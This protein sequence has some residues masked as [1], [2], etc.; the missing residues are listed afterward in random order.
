MKK[1]LSPALFVLLLSASLE[2]TAQTPLKTLL[3]YKSPVSDAAKNYATARKVVLQ[4]GLPIAEGTVEMSVIPWGWSTG[5]HKWH[6]FFS[7]A[8]SS[9]NPER[10]ILLY[11]QTDGQLRLL[12]QE[13]RKNNQVI[14]IQSPVQ[15]ENR[16]EARI[17]FTWKQ[18]KGKC[19]VSLFF[20]G[21][22]LGKQYAKFELATDKLDRN[23]L[24]GDSKRWN[25]SSEFGTA[26]TELVLWNRALSPEQIRF[27][28]ERPA[29]KELVFSKT[30]FVP[31]VKNRFSC[32]YDGPGQGGWL[33]S[34]FDVNGNPAGEQRVD[35]QFPGGSPG[36]FRPLEFEFTPPVLAA[37]T[38]FQWK[39][40]ASCPRILEAKITPGLILRKKPDHYWNGYWIWDEGN[41]KP[42]SYRYFRGTFEVNDPAE[43]HSAYMQWL[44][45]NESEIW[46]NGHNIGR[47]GSW[48][49]PKLT[50]NIAS[51]LRKG[52]NVLAVK[53]F[54][55]SGGAAFLGELT[56][57]RAAGSEYIASSGKWKVAEN[58]GNGWEQPDFDDRS[59]RSSTCKYLPSQNPY[60]MVPYTYFGKQYELKSLPLKSSLKVNGS[61]EINIR[62][63]FTANENIPDREKITV[64]LCK[65]RIPV[66][67]R[68]TSLKKLK[69]GAYETQVSFSFPAD[70]EKGMYEIQ[71]SGQVFRFAGTDRPGKI[72]YFPAPDASR[73]TVAEIKRIQGVPRLT[74]K[75]HPIPFLTYKIGG[76]REDSYEYPVDFFRAGVPICEA[77]LSVHRLWTGDGKIDFSALDAQMEKLLFAVPK[78]MHLIINLSIYAPDWWKKA[79]PCELVAFRDKT[80]PQPDYASLKWRTESVKAV[81]AI[82]D[83]LE[84]KACG[85]RIIGYFFAGGE[86]GQWMQWVEPA[87]RRFSGYS[88]PMKEYFRQ[89]LQRKYGDIAGVNAAWKTAWKD[90]AS[91]EPPPEESRKK[92]SGGFLYD[93]EKQMFQIDFQQSCSDAVTDLVLQYADAVKTRTRWKKIVGLYY[94]KTFSIAGYNGFGEFGIQRLLKSRQIDFFSGVEYYQRDAGK[95]H[96]VSA[97]L[98]SFTLHGKMFMDEADLRTF[99]GG[100]KAWG[101]TGNLW[102]TANTIRKIFAMTAVK[103]QALH[104]FDLHPGE[105]AVPGIMKEIAET[106]GIAKKSVVWPDRKGEVAVITS[107]RSLA[108]CTEEALSYTR[109]AILHQWN[110]LFYRIGTPC[111]FYFLEDI[112][113]PDFPEYKMVVF[114]NAWVLDESLWKAVEKLK[115][116]RA[117]L[118]WFHAP[119][120]IRGN[121]MGPENIRLLTG[122]QVEEAS[123]PVRKVALESTQEVPFLKNIQTVQ[124]YLSGIRPMYYPADVQ[125]V[126]FGKLNDGAAFAGAVKDFGAWRSVFLSAPV[127]TPEVMRKIAEYAG[128]HIYSEDETAMLYI[129]SRL[130]GIHAGESGEKTV[131]FPEPCI[132]KNLTTGKDINARMEK[133][134]KIPMA[135][136]E[137]KLFEKICR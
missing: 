119:G 115:K 36:T 15:F 48:A 84:K 100:A 19:E 109:Q 132:L 4:E 9:V 63:E 67:S 73:E 96:S 110:G 118:V 112:L 74:V 57:N 92:V 49:T 33:L 25:P 105:F 60:G 121:R 129:G 1:I 113:Q 3:Q 101:Y 87:S 116:N 8:D 120:V 29:G 85:G 40:D 94:G 124:S 20:N 27:N 126:R 128:C 54:C 61:Q 50:G 103:N 91:I 80:W 65:N 35:F 47:V 30:D 10:Q 77:E 107:E 86:D 7:A 114:L 81:S 22:L 52:K 111:D 82:V 13:N 69:D 55:H 106:A 125:S 46:L 131:C 64:D 93:P 122:I 58:P 37:R 83:H 43:V 89:W 135:A 21:K 41:P 12:W 16:K 127:M 56:L 44:T 130:F 66:V 18:D 31:G 97:P 70:A 14:A 38:A 71:L 68:I 24:I 59:W 39:S 62:I 134:V 99:A 34:Y 72:E 32:Q 5:E 104:W 26:V 123:F 45:D 76:D 137:T 78:E 53:G 51:F 117:V 98:D 75:G 28:A 108:Y 95:P 11:Q 42:G 136:G 17:A 2:M 88:L 79:N 133:V 102:D 23:L 90:F 6:F